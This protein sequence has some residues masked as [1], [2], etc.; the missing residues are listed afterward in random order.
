MKVKG[1]FLCV[2][3][4]T[5]FAEAAAEL[6]GG[7]DSHQQKHLECTAADEKFET[8]FQRWIEHLFEGVGVAVIRKAI[9]QSETPITLEDR[10]ALLQGADFHNNID[11]KG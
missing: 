10:W 8:S 9:P 1:K 6:L 3:C 11:Y 5:G 4:D 2:V 7:A